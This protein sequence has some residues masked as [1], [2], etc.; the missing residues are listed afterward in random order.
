MVGFEEQKGSA[1]V[2]ALFILVLAVTLTVAVLPMVRQEVSY[3]PVVTEKTGAEYLAQQ[4]VQSCVR[5]IQQRINA[6]NAQASSPGSN[7]LVTRIDPK[8]SIYGT[9]N[10]A[11]GYDYRVSYN[12]VFSGESPNGFRITS[13][14]TV[15]RSKDSYTTTITA[16][17]PIS[18]SRIQGTNP[19]GLFGNAGFASKLNSNGGFLTGSRLPSWTFDEKGNAVAPVYTPNP[20][21]P[22]S[23]DGYYN[24]V[25]FN[26]QLTP[27]TNGN[28]MINYFASCGNFVR[29]HN[30]DNGYGIYYG[31]QSNSVQQPTGYVFQYDPGASIT[32]ARGQSDGGAFF[33]KKVRGGSEIWSGSGKDYRYGFQDNQGTDGNATQNGTVRVSLNQ[34]QTMMQNYYTT[35]PISDLPQYLRN[36]NGTGLNETYRKFSINNQS[37]LITISLDR[38]VDPATNNV[39][40]LQRVFCDGC[41]ILSFVDHDDRKAPG[42]VILSNNTFTN[43]STGFRTWELQSCNFSPTPDYLNVQLGNIMSQSNTMK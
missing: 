20:P 2:L 29:N 8:Y 22:N 14:G 26:N 18:S 5:I 36:A 23:T 9:V 31:C 7:F 27:D 11:N 19:A 13:T 28:Y 32:D 40:Y 30:T 16:L 21:N 12:P 1:L 42:N 17:A 38:M 10:A 43:T 39:Y 6:L 34:L 3:S 33:V 25:N 4:G 24:Y 41:Q 37:H 35:T 15:K